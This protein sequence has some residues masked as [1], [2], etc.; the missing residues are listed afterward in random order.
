MRTTFLALSLAVLTAGVMPAGSISL[1]GT[2]DQVAFNGHFDTITLGESCPGTA[3]GTCVY[4]GSQT[5]GGG[6]LTW[7]FS[8][9]NTASNITWDF[10]GDVF[11][12][13]GGTFSASDGVD[14][15][16]ATYVLNSWTYDGVP[17]QN[18]EDGIDLNG[19]ISVTGLTLAGGGD[20]NEAAFESFLSL[21]GATSYSFI[22]DVGNCTSGKKNTECIQPTDPSASFIS[23]TLDPN[24]GTPEP[25]TLALMTLGL[26]S[27]FG[28][29]RRLKKAVSA[30]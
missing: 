3:P 9:P 7:G 24:I 4:G 30:R 1:T 13:V 5:L 11:G 28:A 29:R 21:P 20:T 19:L 18:G 8:T 14:S 12:P 6:T 15:F 25:G 26:L 17:D 23:F 2:T 16:N 22:L 27:A 10:L